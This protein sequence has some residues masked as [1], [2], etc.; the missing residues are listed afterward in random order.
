MIQNNVKDEG[1]SSI[2]IERGMTKEEVQL[3]LTASMGDKERAFFRAIYETWFRAQELL[4]CNIED[5][6]KSTGQLVCLNP[7]RKYSKKTKTSYQPP[8]K[9]M[10]VSKATQILF[11]SIIGNR[12]KGPIFVNRNGIRCS[13]TYFQMYIDMIATKLGIQRVTHVTSTGRKYH[14]VT[15][16]ALREAGERHTDMAGAD[17]A[18]TAKGAQHTLEV[19]EQYYEKFGWEEIQEQVKKYHPAFKES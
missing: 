15:L 9:Q 14:L 19:K 16:Q 8:P 17:R 2:N 4:K 11:R 5:Y 6:N 12:K 7:K 3:L 13:V 10:I 18:L 1:L